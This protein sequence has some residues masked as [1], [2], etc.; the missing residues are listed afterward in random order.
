MYTHSLTR[1]LGTLYHTMDHA[2]PQKTCTATEAYDVVSSVGSPAGQDPANAMWT[3]S[4][5]VDGKANCQRLACSLIMGSPGSIARYGSTAVYVSQACPPPFF[6]KPF[7]Y[8]DVT[9]EAHDMT[10]A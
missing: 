10:L 4:G 1:L 2:N 5:R 6:S 3:I 9:E 8:L 7:F